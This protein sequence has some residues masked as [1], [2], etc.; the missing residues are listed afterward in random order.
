MFDVVLLSY[1][2]PRADVAYREL[3]SIVPTAKRVHGI[4][5]IAA[6][7][8]AAANRCTTEM[9]FVVDADAIDI[10][11]S[12]FEFEPPVWDREYTHI[13]HAKNSTND[14]CYGYGGIKCFNRRIVA[15]FSG[16]YTDFS[17]TVAS[18]K[19]VPVVASTT[20]FDTSPFLTFRAVV[21]EVYKLLL[22]INSDDTTSEDKATA[23]TRLKLWNTSTPTTFH[24]IAYMLGLSTAKQLH[25]TGVH[26]SKINDFEYLRM[27]WNQL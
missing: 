26:K 25:D 2:E 4:D 17:S 14:N 16:E 20:K 6:A 27:V 1:D 24:R 10:N 7:H 15:N 23:I 3:Q 13:W 8:I 22:C 18:L 11:G 21:R 12:V 5:G 19:V 9:F